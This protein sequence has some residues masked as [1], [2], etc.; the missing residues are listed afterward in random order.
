MKQFGSRKSKIVAFPWSQNSSALAA[1]KALEERFGVSFSEF[2]SVRTPDVQER[3]DRS[4]KKETLKMA[5]KYMN[6]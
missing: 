5:S 1:R 6:D 2:F 4:L 3:I